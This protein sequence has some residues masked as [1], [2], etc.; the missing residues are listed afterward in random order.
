V[1]TAVPGDRVRRASGGLARP[2]VPGSTT[3]TAAT[4]AVVV[5]AL[6]AASAP[7]P[8]IVV[9]LGQLAL[10]AAAAFL[11][12]DAAAELT[13]VT[14]S[15]L[16][17]RRA[18]AVLAGSAVLVASWLVVVVG[19]SAPSPEVLSGEA[20]V[21]LLATLA[22]STLLARGG[23]EEPGA[24]VACAVLLGGVAAMLTA[25]LV[26]RGIFLSDS[27]PDPRWLRLT[28]SGIATASLLALAAGGREPA[29]GS[30]RRR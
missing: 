2:R 24:T 13:G 27:P 11:L 25:G 8:G 23:E 28:W 17:V 20:A 14:P 1:S 3:A 15:P 30:R 19:S 26:G 9:H 21:L 22:A 6:H 29:R 5:A 7:V 16:W 12:D 4:V 10:A 18:P